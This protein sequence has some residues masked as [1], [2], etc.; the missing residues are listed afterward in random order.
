MESQ[1]FFESHQELA[2][3]FLRLLIRYDT[4]SLLLNKLVADL[5][6]LGKDVEETEII[7]LLADDCDELRATKDEGSALY[8]KKAQF[9]DSLLKQR[10]DAQE[11]QTLEQLAGA[12]SSV[13]PG[14]QSIPQENV[15]PKK[16]SS[17]RGRR[18]K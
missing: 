8:Q 10:D 2:E 16:Q 13:P 7:Q 12:G 9:L 14:S 11:I 3:R 18:K 15:A 6:A 5:K 4:H 17:T 1:S